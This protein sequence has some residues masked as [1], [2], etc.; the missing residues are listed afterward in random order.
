MYILEKRNKKHV[1]VYGLS[2][3]Y[4]FLNSSSVVILL[5]PFTKV[6]VKF[7]GIN[8]YLVHYWQHLNVI[9]LA[10]YEQD[11]SFLYIFI[12]NKYIIA[13]SPFLWML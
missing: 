1:I 3:V 11:I 5:I 6:T 7:E 12:R 10:R 4:D 8:L 13:S 9:F 2:E